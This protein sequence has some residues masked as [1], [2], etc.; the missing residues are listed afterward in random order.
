MTLVTMKKQDFDSLSDERLGW[1]CIEPTFQQIRGKNMSVKTQV[2]SKLTMGQQALCM[3]RAMYD[4]AKNSAAEYY[5]WLSHL[6]DQPGY[7]AGV[8]DSLRFFGDDSMILLLEETK[9]SLGARNLKLGIQWSNAALKDL[10]HDQELL[11]EVHLLF[12]RFQDISP[13]SLKTISSYIRSHPKAFV[14]IEN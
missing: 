11:R 9:E 13:D 1:A 5:C 8:T 14:N 3:F 4:H 12:D 6:M 10:D 2:I 7:W